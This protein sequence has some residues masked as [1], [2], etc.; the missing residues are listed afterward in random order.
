MA[1]K[2]INNKDCPIE[3]IKRSPVHSKN[4]SL[5]VKG[6]KDNDTVKS[7]G[8]KLYSILNQNSDIQKQ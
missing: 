2:N 8:N 4:I 1:G 5:I 7:P 3:L 6:K